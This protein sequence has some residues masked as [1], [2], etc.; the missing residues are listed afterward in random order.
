MGT[1]AVPSNCIAPD[2]DVACHVTS[3]SSADT[4]GLTV[5]IC[6]HRRARSV[7]RCLDSFHTQRRRPA[8]LLIVDASPDRQTELCI[9]HRTD[10]SRLA[11]R[12]E[13]VRVGPTLAGLTRQRNFALRSVTTDFV[14]FFDDDVV[15]SEGCLDEMEA[16]IKSADHADVVGVGAVAQNERRTPNRLW[17]ARR[18]LHM[19]DSLRAGRY[20]RSGMS[21]AW[22]ALD[23]SQP[24]ADADWLPG[25][26]MLWK[27]DIA[28]RVGFNEQFAG[29][30]NGEDLDFSLRMARFGRLVIATGARLD[31]HHEPAGR[32]DPYAL[33]FSTIRNA[34]AIHSRC[35]QPRRLRDISWFGYAFALDTLIQCAPV[36]SPPGPAWRFA[37]GRGRV[38][39][40]VSL[41][42]HRGSQ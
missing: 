1:T 3:G 40:L 25:Y 8:L 27:T 32:P 21:V 38:A 26:A 18:L 30:A 29:Y 12:F 14:A 36:L 31:H 2:Q 41:L 13:Y 42:M 23:R 10:L 5:V 28:R 35:L 9:R 20:C 19:V 16:A 34:W 7:E 39:C 4:R 24:I 22:D 33:G 11:T 37:Y 15:L 6:T 17:R